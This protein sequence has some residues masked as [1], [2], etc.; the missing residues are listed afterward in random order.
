MKKRILTRTALF[1]SLGLIFVT[2]AIAG[3][4]HGRGYRHWEGAPAFSEACAGK[5]EGDK[6]QVNTPRGR[7]LDA[8]CVQMEDGALRAWP[9]RAVKHHEAMLAAC[10]GKK[11]GEKIRFTDMRGNE[12]EALCEKRGA[13]LFP[14]PDGPRGAWANKRAVFEAC[15]GKK[16]G[17][18]VQVETPCGIPVDGTCIQ[19][20]KELIAKT[21]NA[22]PCNGWNQGQGPRHGWKGH[23]WKGHKKGTG[24]GYGRGYENAPCWEYYGYGPGN[25][26]NGMGYG[27]IQRACQGKAKGEKVSFETPCGAVV[28]ITCGETPSRQ[29]TSSK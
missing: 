16:P 19:K 23:G 3:P 6:V 14:I 24:Y 17:D 2:S 20:G 22:S 11:E 7:T 29:P 25:G 13:E 12:R 1:A 9:E 5:T 21:G 10:K 27:V 8:V 18:K 28:D 15:Q 26:A 4:H